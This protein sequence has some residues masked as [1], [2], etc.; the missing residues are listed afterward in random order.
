MKQELSILI[1]VFNYDCTSLTGQLCRQVSML[2]ERCRSKIEIIVAEDGSTDLA[3]LNANKAISEFPFCR[4]IRREV[5]VGRATIRNV[6]AQEAAYEWLLFLDCDMQVPNDKFLQCY[7]ETGGQEVID[8]G[9]K[10]LRNDQMEGHNLRYTYEWYAQERHSVQ[11]RR[12]CPY[13]SFRTTN[14]M[15]RR[16]IM[17]AHPFDERFLLYGYE[18]VLFGKT[19]K[20]HGIGIEHIDNSMMLADLEKNEV[21]VEKTEEAL[22]TLHEF[23]NDLRGYSRLLIV[24]DGI[25][26]LLVHAV[27]RLW[28][29]LFGSLERRNLCG[30]HP[31][32]RIFSLYKIGYYLTLTK[33]D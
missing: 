13:R 5:N 26:I 21:F 1:P 2:T 11:Q 4:Y 32:L 9:F 29:R 15:V 30:N 19:L 28:H 27:I 3:A 31:N 17:L 12:K 16:D 6:L 14:F 10:V 23:R 22:R 24:V 18:D 33:N 25:H 8:G 20:Q 7:M